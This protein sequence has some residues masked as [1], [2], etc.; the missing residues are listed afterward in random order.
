MNN[1]IMN[2]IRN[3]GILSDSSAIPGRVRKDHEK[4]FDWSNS[5]NF[6][7][8]PSI[9]NYQDQTNVSEK[10]LE[11]PMNTIKIKTS[12]DKEPI[13]RYVNL[14]F[15]PKLMYQGLN[16]F[17]VNKETLVTITHPFE[18][19]KN[20]KINEGLISYNVDTLEKNILNLIQICKKNNKKINFLKISELIKKY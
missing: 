4:V 14:S 9:K 11:I 12:Y 13:L 6:P 2:F 8:H 20:F 3:L 10:F 17:I 15:I 5:Q 18:L 19:F 16:D 7:Y 1:N